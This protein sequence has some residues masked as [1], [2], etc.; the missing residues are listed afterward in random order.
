MTG[1][2]IP[3]YAEVIRRRYFLGSKKEKGKILDKF[4]EVTGRHR[5]A[6]FRIIFHGSRTITGEKRGCPRQYVAAVTGALRVAREVTDRLCSKRLHPFCR[7]GQKNRCLRREHR[8][9]LA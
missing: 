7:P 6:A 3:E 8:L 5:R 1:S 4:T 2:S 9:P